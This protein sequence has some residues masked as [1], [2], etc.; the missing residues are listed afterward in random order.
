[1]ALEKNLLSYSIRRKSG[2]IGQIRVSMIE[3]VGGHGGMELYNVPLC[4]GLAELDVDLALFTCDETKV[5]GGDLFSTRLSYQR[6]FGDSAAWLRGI[7]YL[8][9]SLKA[10]YATVLERRK[11]VHLHFFHVGVLSFIDLLLGRLLCRKVV[12]SAHDVESFVSSLEAPFV[13]RL[14]YRLAHR[15]IAHNEFSKSE[16]QARLH[17][18]QEKISVV[19]LGNLIPSLAS[20]PATAEARAKLKIPEGAAVLLFFG[21]IKEVKGLDILI[22]AIPDLLKKHPNLI[23]LI[24]GKPWKTNFSKYQERIEKFDLERACISHIKFI[25]NEEIPV[26]YSAANLVVLPY[27]RIYQSGILLTAMSYRKAVVV[28]DIPGMLESVRD[29]VTGFTFKCG[30]A[31]DLSRR[32]DE[33]LSDMNKVAQVGDSGYELVKTQHAWSVVSQKTRNVYAELYQQ[34]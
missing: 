25:P 23:L 7:R 10:M 31:K 20:L 5:S 3:P 1:M 13:S 24:A 27:L 30:D 33:A 11:I 32:I 21:Q 28:S 16:L 19:P 4:N 9:G 17:V 6:I 29:G 12:V 15:V 14:A 34:R 8:W 2:I 26:Y 18:A 22:D